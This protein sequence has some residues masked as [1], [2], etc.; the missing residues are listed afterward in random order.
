VEVSHYK[1]LN[2]FRLVLAPWH[3]LTAFFVHTMVVFSL[4]NTHKKNFFSSL[5]PS[6]SLQKFHVERLT[7]HFLVF[8]LE[9]TTI[10]A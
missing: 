2:R 5:S 8:D 7:M 9:G 10:F 4:E 6:L 1:A 3:T